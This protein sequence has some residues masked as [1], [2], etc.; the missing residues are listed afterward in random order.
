MRVEFFIKIVLAIGCCLTIPKIVDNKLLNSTIDKRCLSGYL[1][2]LRQQLELMLLAFLS[3]ISAGM[4][5]RRSH[6]GLS[7]PTDP[8]SIHCGLSRTFTVMYNACFC[9]R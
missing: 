7:E 5:D 1:A 4:T 2:S 3:K 6:L 8:S 9:E